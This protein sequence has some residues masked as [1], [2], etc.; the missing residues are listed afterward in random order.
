MKLTTS[1]FVFVLISI[2]V[3]V[4][5]VRDNEGVQQTTNPRIVEHPE[6]TY[7]ARNEPATL[8]C[9]AEG[10]PN[11]IVTW[12]RNDKPIVT[13]NDNPTSHRMLLP[14]GQLFFL[15]VIH[16]RHNKPDVGV[17]YCNATNPET[18]AAA[19][20]RTAILDIAT[21]NSDFLLNPKNTDAEPN[22]DV[23]LACESPT[24]QPEPRISWKKDGKSLRLSDRHLI[25]KTGSLRIVDVGHED[26]GLYV[27]VAYNA[28]GERES[29]PANLVIRE[30]PRAVSETK[31]LIVALNSVALL[32]CHA[33][34]DPPP[35]ILWR[36]SIGQISSERSKVVE[37]RSLRIENV[38]ISDEG[39]YVCRAENDAGHHEMSIRLTIHS[40]PSFLVKPVD[41][42]V[43]LG[44]RASFRCEV[45]GSPWPSIFWNKE[46]S[47]TFM[48]PN[49][50]HGRFSVSEDG[51]L[52]I[53]FV[54]REDAGQYTCK[55]LSVSG[56]AIAAAMLEVKD[57]LLEPPPII[58]YGPV[59]QTL[60]VSTGAML[61]C[62]ASG[63]PSPVIRWF[64]NGRI[65]PLKDPRF[66]LL[67][68]GSLQ[69][70]DLRKTDAGVYA[71]KAV[72]DVG[73]TISRSATLLVDA[74]TNPS[75]I[76]H[77]T[78]EP[79]SLPGPPS[80]PIASEITERSIRLSWKANV[81]NGGSSVF[82]FSVEYFSQEVTDGW[83]VVLDSIPSQTYTLTNLRPDTFYFFLIR[84]QNQQ[85]IGPP[86]QV[87]G[88]IKTKGVRSKQSIHV[89]EYL[90]PS[91]IS[92]K[93][94]GQ[95]I[96]L[97]QP[98][99]I[100][101]TTVKLS[102]ELR[103]SH[104]YVDGVI[105]KFRTIVDPEDRP[106]IHRSSRLNEFN[107]VTVR[108][109]S[110]MT[111]DLCNLE[112][113]TW[114]EIRV[115]PYYASIKGQESNTIRIRMPEDVPSYPP[116]NIMASVVDNSTLYLSWQHPKPSTTNGPLLG[117]KIYIQSSDATWNKE[118][119]VNSSTDDLYIHHL[120]SDCTY[121]LQM[122][123]RNRIGESARSESVFIGDSLESIVK[124]SNYLNEAWLMVTLIALTGCILWIGTSLVCA[125]IYKRRKDREKA[126]INSEILPTKEMLCKEFDS[127]SSF[128]RVV[129]T[130]NQLTHQQSE[131]NS[132]NFANHD[133]K[134][135]ISGPD[136]VVSVYHQPA[137]I[138]EAPPPLADRNEVPPSWVQRHQAPP[139]IVQRHHDLNTA[140]PPRSHNRIVTSN[141]DNCLSLH[142]RISS[143]FGKSPVLFL[144][145][146]P[147]HP[148]SPTDVET[149]KAVATLEE[150]FPD[151]VALKFLPDE[152]SL[153][154]LE[155]ERQ[156][157]SSGRDI[158]PEPKNIYLSNSRILSNQ[159]YFMYK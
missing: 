24:G 28:A 93:L 105:I 90:D 47:H 33:S 118:I 96:G 59:N 10:E 57:S 20:S 142:S 127:T 98:E 81:I 128:N 71:C 79:S 85:G 109:N 115:Q 94:S 40:P 82:A 119:L 107:S 143:G 45:T 125:W 83:T 86:S 17:Y 129:H 111:Y 91:L 9:K 29:K 50:D 15:R 123:A 35:V 32:K 141:P 103:R 159:K 130:L 101:S 34:G 112:K 120:I 8:N 39:I 27:C 132:A 5:A 55:A 113:Y 145:P 158:S 124:V 36:K 16:N 13:A 92:E 89:G 117:Y 136:H 46:T 68:S 43:G 21:I 114:Y 76:F 84:A 155:M 38:Q 150:L 65:V 78:P 121:R 63:E 131:K 140:P 139:T 137:A 99:L 58:R 135:W 42:V 64:K 154:W 70:T 138:S 134:A 104:R 69:I 48:F 4:I 14:S 149:P 7:V 133:G 95:V 102:W 53:E 23:E 100:N 30:K 66:F 44:Q 11:P 22:V 60:P 18:G 56:S 61:Q 1:C 52:V 74:P 67:E 88:P 116:S 151:R 153:R 19:V 54:Q 146:P 152:R 25:G 87:T 108:G 106:A 97:F 26:A 37:D 72:S 77:R 126:K 75:V 157:D 12:Y 156:T 2:V 122:S 110:V 144:P 41:R 148:P 3:V 49:Q 6:D 80:R 51:T 31:E 147:D 62:S 73:E